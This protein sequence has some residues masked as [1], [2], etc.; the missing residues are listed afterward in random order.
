MAYRTKASYRGNTIESEFKQLVKDLEN[1][2]L[3]LILKNE[4][5]ISEKAL[6]R[7]PKKHQTKIKTIEKKKA[8]KKLQKKKYL[9]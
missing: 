2:G 3:K 7:I 8:K 4:N 6:I 1:M 5:H 9:R